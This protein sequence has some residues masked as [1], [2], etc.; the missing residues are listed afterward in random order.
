MTAV[1]R[2]PATAP[3]VTQHRSSAE[4]SLQAAAATVRLLPNTSL[5]SPVAA[6]VVAQVPHAPT[7]CAPIALPLPVPDTLPFP[8]PVPIAIPVPAAVIP[9]IGPA[10]HVC[11]AAEP[12]ACGQFQQPKHTVKY[13]LLIYAVPVG[14][15]SSSDAL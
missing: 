1:P 12:D 15:S 4:Y 7:V 6:V 5:T 9:A 11:A 10:Q 8:I 14:S 2:D 3:C 13:S